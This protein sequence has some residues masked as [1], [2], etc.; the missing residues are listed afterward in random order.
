MIGVV[1]DRRDV[2]VTGR[3]PHAAEAIR[4]GDGAGSRRS[5]QISGAAGRS[6]RTV[7]SKSVAQSRAGARADRSWCVP[8]GQG[9]V[10]RCVI[11][12]VIEDPAPHV[13]DDRGGSGSLVRSRR[14]GDHDEPTATEPTVGRDRGR[15][16]RSPWRLTTSTPPPWCS[17]CRPPPPRRCCPARLRGRPDGRRRG[18]ARDRR[19]RLPAEPVGRLPRST[20]ASWPVPGGRATR[21]SARSCTAC[22]STR[23]SPA[24]PATR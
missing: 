2:L 18:P 7:W 16:S 8:L 13:T 21:S 23:S 11:V 15:P 17:R 4:V 12:R 20:S 10:A 22:P 19:V 6:R 3:Q 5:S 9:V 14:M 24:R 1:G